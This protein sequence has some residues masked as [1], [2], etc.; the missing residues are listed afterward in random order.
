MPEPE[1]EH[2]VESVEHAAWDPIDFWKDGS[3]DE[4]DLKQ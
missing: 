4:N 3:I 1:Q 2:Q